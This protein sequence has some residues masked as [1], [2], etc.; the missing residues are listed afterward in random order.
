MPFFRRP[1]KPTLYYCIDDFTDPWTKPETIVLQHG[2]ARS[3]RFWYRW[4]PH[5]ARH[6]KVVR[7][8]LRGHGGSPVE[9]DPAT[10]ST[11]ENYV[12]DITALLDEL[13]LGAVHYCGESFGGIIGMVLAADAPRR[14]KTLT[15]VASPV[16]QNAHAAYAA[17]FPTRQEA[18]RTLGTP[19]WAQ[20]IYGAPGFFPPDTDRGLRDW[21]VGEIGK[22]DAEMLCGLYALVSQANASGY[23]PRISVPVL[24]LYPTSGSLTSAEQETLLTAGIRNFDLV[25][26]P[27]SSH[28]ILTL[29]PDTCVRHLLSFVGQGANGQSDEQRQRPRPVA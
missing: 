6:Y 29:E 2:Y 20:A 25:H 21:Y 10:E 9:F 22:C 24:G 16:Y 5:L 27:T 23:L 4:V 8:D 13:D 17:G 26:L 19:K 7:M 12:D 28:A 18:L 1:A 14:V 15:L 11:M 3:S